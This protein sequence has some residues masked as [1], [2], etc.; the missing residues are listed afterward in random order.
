MNIAGKEFRGMQEGE[1]PPD[2]P[3]WVEMSP[4]RRQRKARVD[5][6][7]LRRRIKQTVAGTIFLVV[8]GAGWLYP[9]VGYFI[10]LCMLLGIG[11]AAFR[12]RS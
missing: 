5:K 3:H 10:P 9:L 2:R 12:G 7:Q 6:A 1:P 8:L 11:L 4:D